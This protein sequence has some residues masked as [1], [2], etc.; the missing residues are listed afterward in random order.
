MM[1]DG[2]FVFLIAAI[3]TLFFSI[4]TF[5]SYFL[6]PFL[7]GLLAF[8]ELLLIISGASG[9]GCMIVK[10]LGFSDISP[11]QK[12]LIG[13]S[14]GLGILSLSAFFLA[15]IHYLN[16]V[17]LTVFL[18]IVWIVG[19]TELKALFSSVNSAKKML[20]SRPFASL[21]SLL[22]LSLVLWCCLIPPHQYDSLVYHLPLAANYVKAHGLVKTP[23]LFYSHFP[24]NGEMLF[25]ISLLLKS[26]ILAQMFMWFSLFLSSWWI[27]EIARLE[28]PMEAVILSIVLLLTQSSVMLL[29]ASSYVEPLVM[30]W[31]TASVLSFLR[32][33]EIRF[34][35]PDSK[36]W[37]ILSAVFSGLALG[38]KYY[39]G[40]TVGI[41][42][43]ALWGRIIFP[44]NSRSQALKDAISFT[45]IVSILFSPWMIKNWLWAHNPFFPFF[46][47]L[48]KTSA[49]AWN[50][51][52]AQ[53]YF[54]ALAEYR[55]GLNYAHWFDFPLMLLT[56]SLHFG[57]GMDVLGG[58]GWEILFW[59]LP[60]AVWFSRKNQ[61]LRRLLAFSSI[62]IAVWFLTGVVLR[63]LIVLCP[64]LCL[65]AGN[66]LEKLKERLSPSSKIIL[67]SAVSLLIL[68]HLLLFLFVNFG[69]FDAGQVLLGLK[70]RTEYL[71]QR[72]LYY[73]CAN[74]AS[75]HAKRND[76]IL[77]MGEQRSY[78]APAGS[79]ASSIF[80]PNLLIEDSNSS[81]TEKELKSKLK[82]KGVTEILWVP[83]EMRR[84]GDSLGKFTAPGEINFQNLLQKSPILYRSSG[85][86]LFSVK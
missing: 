12:T 49:S 55:S 75:Q 48:F 44:K 52:V 40:I 57:R 24:Q 18:S 7:P 32:W 5:A 27:F 80:A 39:A 10:S 54:N 63:F 29:S 8:L 56:N 82:Q 50:K 6:L 65:L 14:L 33:E 81:P 3:L 36:A 70:S 84:L 77:I 43:T 61:F 38:T 67:I 66:A 78:Y 73:P 28:I 59:S 45:L 42:G 60:L 35:S 23:W 17:A 1:R 15:A 85:C 58:L 83:E 41:L 4:Y 53:N 30:L 19:F 13:A 69:V 47:P 86:I 31:T 25:T 74:Y 76:K 16:L 21:I 62:Y 51:E 68:T 26:D 2:K 72:L 46:N 20:L 79:I 34:A 37:L 11:S 64:L 22:S 71:S 9:V